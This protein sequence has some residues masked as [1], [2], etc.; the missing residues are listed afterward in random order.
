M[1]LTIIIRFWRTTLLV[2]ALF[3]APLVFE[4]LVKPRHA[5]LQDHWWL[6]LCV[7]GL[8]W[9]VP[10][11]VLHA[12]G[13]AARRARLTEEDLRRNGTPALA[14]VLDVRDRWRLNEEPILELTLR[15][16][17]PGCAPFDVKLRRITSLPDLPSFQRGSTVHVH[18]D[19]K[20]RDRIAIDEP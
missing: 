20:R 1:L 16:T 19:P 15:V 6:D 17:P 8:P 12:F 18:Y 5:L 4:L 10:L 3:S 9:T 14:T 13:S 7:Y 2:I 11:V